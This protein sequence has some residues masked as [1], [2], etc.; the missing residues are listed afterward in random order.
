M[1]C[2]RFYQAMI[3]LYVGLWYWH[4]IL[5]IS[6]SN[7]ICVEYKIF[8]PSFSRTTILYSSDRVLLTLRQQIH[9]RKFT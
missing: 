2:T 5:N 1:V 7:I 3:F 4:E 9:F 8:Q 6:F